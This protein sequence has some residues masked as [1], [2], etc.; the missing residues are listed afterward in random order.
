MDEEVDVQDEH[1]C[2]SSQQPTIAVQQASP[3][4][5]SVAINSANETEKSYAKV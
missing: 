4:G 1:H 3:D 5:A 2:L